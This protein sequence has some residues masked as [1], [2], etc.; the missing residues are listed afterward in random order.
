M[1]LTLHHRVSKNLIIHF[2]SVFCC[3]MSCFLLVLLTYKV[4]CDILARKYLSGSYGPSKNI[5]EIYILCTSPKH[6]LLYS[7]NLP[8]FPILSL[9]LFSSPHITQAPLLYA[10]NLPHFYPLFFVNP[11]LLPCSF[12][13]PF[14]LYAILVIL[15]SPVI[16][17]A[18]VVMVVA[19][20]NVHEM[21]P[22]MKHPF[23]GDLLTA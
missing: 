18:C 6:S 1:H 16:V 23:I 2:F 21:R 19:C 9:A 14:L 3:A 4:G 20:D 15:S 22:H 17:P 8:H 10:L 12:L 11:S 5:N 7:P 13:P